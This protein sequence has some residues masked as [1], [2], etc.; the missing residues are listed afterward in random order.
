MFAAGMSEDL[1]S[2]EEVCARLEAEL[3]SGRAG[4]GWKRMVPPEG[5]IDYLLHDQ[6]EL[7][8]RQR[9]YKKSFLIV[10]GGAYREK[11]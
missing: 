3:A 1:D 11:R 10:C 6:R 7:K 9:N 5:S 8:R 2:A 4:E